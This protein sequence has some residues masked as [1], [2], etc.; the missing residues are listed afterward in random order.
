[1]ETIADFEKWIET[2]SSELR[3]Q[4]IA[5]KRLAVAFAQCNIQLIRRDQVARLGI[6]KSRIMEEVESLKRI[7]SAAQMGATKGAFWGGAAAFT[8]G[9]LFAAA[10]GRQD[11]YY[12]GA[13]MAGSVLSRKVPFGTVLITIDGQGI[14]K[15]VKVVS[16]SRL[17]RESSMSESEV[18]TSL[19]HDGYLLMTPEV[20]AKVLE[21][22]DCEILDGSV[23]LPLARSEVMKRLTR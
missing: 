21:K 23:C 22:V 14:P 9:S 7:E 10:K 12:I 20:F 3:Q 2:T 19:K 15:G 13:Q 16:I 5:V 1:M 8:I 17:A 6:L 11:A 18:E 4:T